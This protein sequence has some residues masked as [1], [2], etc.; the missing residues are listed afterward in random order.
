MGIVVISHKGIAQDICTSML[1]LYKV[2][3]HSFNL[4]EL[5]NGKMQE[6]GDI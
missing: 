3:T 6:K 5:I 4:D 2:Y 1:M